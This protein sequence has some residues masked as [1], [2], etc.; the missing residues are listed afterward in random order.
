MPASD[1]K[2]VGFN[3]GIN[4]GEVAAHTVFHVH[5]HLIPRRSGDVDDPSGGVGAS[6][7][8]CRNTNRAD[9][10]ARN[11]RFRG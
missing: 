6:F 9:I 7:Q 1:K 4:V 5:V 10:M 2:I 3:V 8:K 11:V